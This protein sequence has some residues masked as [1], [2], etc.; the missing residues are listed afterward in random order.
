M[1][2]TG[3]LHET[4][5]VNPRE[6]EARENEARE[7]ETRETY[8]EPEWNLESY[9]PSVVEGR[10]RLPAGIKEEGFVYHAARFMA[11]G[12]FDP[13][14]EELQETKH[15]RRVSPTKLRDKSRID[16]KDINAP[17]QIKIR[18]TEILYR[19]A[20]FNT[21]DDEYRRRTAAKQL[22]NTSAEVKDMTLGQINKE[23]GS[24]F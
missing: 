8:R 20:E 22:L 5:N 24:E 23:Y 2:K 16:P 6:H 13:R 7:D 3:R 1:N 18:D 15:W 11:R 4:R 14:S 19:P 9:N 12:E 21:R 17:F 10:I